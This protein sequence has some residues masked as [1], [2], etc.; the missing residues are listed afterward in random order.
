[1]T[2]SEF[3]KDKKHLEEN[4]QK[5][6]EDLKVKQQTLHLL[7]SKLWDANDFILKKLNKKEFYEVTQK[8]WKHFDRFWEFQNLAD[9]EGKINPLVRQWK[10]NVDNWISACLKN[11][12]IIKRFDEIMCE[13]ASKFS[14]D[15][16]RRDIGSYLK[17]EDLNKHMEANNK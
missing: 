1:M 9:F 5:L 4:I 8:I 12:S 14:I 13:K 17:I 16:V 3:E 15:E 11:E 10:E 6:E 2:R 7:D